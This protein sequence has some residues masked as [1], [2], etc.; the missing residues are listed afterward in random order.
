MNLFNSIYLKGTYTKKTIMGHPKIGLWLT[1]YLK[2]THNWFLGSDTS[3]K[4]L[5]KGKYI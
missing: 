1:F 4:G 3:P 2:S 5:F